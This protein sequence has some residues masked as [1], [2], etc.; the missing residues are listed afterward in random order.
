MSISGRLFYRF[1]VSL[2]ISFGLLIGFA[3][4]GFSQ[5]KSFKKHH[6]TKKFKNKKFKKP[7][8]RF[9]EPRNQKEFEADPEKKEEAFIK[10]RMFPFDK[11]PENARLKAF[12]SR[13][14]EASRNSKAIAQ[15]SSIGPRSTNSAF[16]NK[17]NRGFA[18]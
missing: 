8:K 11:L 17:C 1:A 13:P 10:E 5:S 3:E 16:P 15:W 18:C 9:N 4:S 14:E 12:E 2:F 7:I 6:V